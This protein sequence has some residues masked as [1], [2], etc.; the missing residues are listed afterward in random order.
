MKAELIKKI[1]HN[2]FPKCACIGFAIILYIFGKTSRL[3]SRSIQI[4]VVVLEDENLSRTSGK[5]LNVT[6]NLRSESDIVSTFTAKDLEAVI[7]LTYFTKPGKYDVPVNVT[8]SSEINRSVPIEVTVTPKKVSVDLEER[9]RKAVPVNVPVYGNP[10]HGYEVSDIKVSPQQV[11]ISGPKSMV[12][13]ITQVP[14]YEID[15][16]DKKDNFT[17]V[18]KVRGLNRHI[19][20]VSSDQINVDVSFNTS[21][22]SK[23]FKNCQVFLAHLDPKFE[24]VMIP[25]ISFT[26][27]G[28]ELV[29]EKFYPSEYTVQADCKSVNQP[30]EYELP[31]VIA[32]Q[33]AFKLEEQS[34][35]T[36]KF[37]V[38]E[39]QVQIAPV[40]ENGNE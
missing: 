7:D 38:R 27:S 33:D 4:P 20:I 28:A 6:V 8:L 1:T 18:K 37:Q 23:S 24:A 3:E 30:G 9:I 35:A 16:T 12:E 36:V 2:W 14:T 31:V 32:I 19:S 13:S 40:S 10:L 29:L 5:P 34:A 22:V 25:E 21:L 15:L 39:K 17:E 11:L 26:V